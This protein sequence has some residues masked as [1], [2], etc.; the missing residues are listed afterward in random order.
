MIGEFYD[1]IASLKDRNEVRSFF[2]SL[3]SA[4]E[5]AT[6]MRRVEI[7]VLLSAKFTYDEITE[8][9]GVGKS[10][11]T[12]VQKNLLQDDSGYKIIVKR[13]IE[14]RKKRLIK[15]RKEEKDRASPFSF[16]KKKYA[17]YFLL[18]NLLDVAIQKL[19]LDDKELEKE[20]LL[21]TPSAGLK[22][23]NKKEVRR[24]NP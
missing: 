5:I 3:L 23:R 15:A 17:G 20:A 11:I 18:E 1:S 12:N 13:L 24:K 14:D 9:M 8:L 10:K 7:A 16:V 22:I 6:L 4:D 21:Y 2:K 19:E